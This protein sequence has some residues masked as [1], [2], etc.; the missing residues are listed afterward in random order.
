MSKQV[1]RMTIEPTLCA[2][3]SEPFIPKMRTQVACGPVCRKVRQ[4]ESGQKLD[5]KR[6]HENPEYR[7]K[8]IAKSGFRY[9]ND[10]DYRKRE[11]DRR[12]NEWANR[13]VPPCRWC[14][15]EFTRNHGFRWFCS[16]ECRIFD[17]RLRSR[18]IAKFRYHH[19][20]EF[21]KK[22]DDYHKKRR[23]SDPEFRRKELGWQRAWLSIPGNRDKVRA[24]MAMYRER[25]RAEDPNWEAKRA[26]EY[27]ERKIRREALAELMVTIG[28]LG[29]MTDEH[30]YPTCPDRL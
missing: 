4:K 21:R 8:Q 10:A 20:P 26:A 15:V 5:R 24:A 19:D 1:A 12:K 25:R 16:V 2:V 27:R 13:P 18:V 9:K 30:S 3:C 14:G 29:E 11:S 7:A 23:R 6:Y 22:R 28:T 17:R